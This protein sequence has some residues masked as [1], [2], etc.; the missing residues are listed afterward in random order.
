MRSI[1]FLCIG[2]LVCTSAQA[3]KVLAEG[4]IRYNISV[5]QGA[6]NPGVADAFAGASQ[7]VYF[8]SYKARTDFTSPV[9]SQST[10]YDAQS[11]NGFVLNQSGQDKY[12]IPLEGEKWMQYNKKYKGLAFAPASGSKQIAGYSCKKALGKAADG[13][14][15]TVYYTSDLVV[16]AKGYD[17]MF[18]SLDGMPLEYEITSNGVTINYAASSV[19]TGMVS[20]ATFDAP[21]TGYKVL[22]IKQ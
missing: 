4:Y 1:W 20:A 7:I 3:Q 12:M 22:E 17:A 16:M 19:Q 5:T 15:I 9:R 8:K 10:V 13:T 21:K 14:E 2:I 6:S 18:A 11:S